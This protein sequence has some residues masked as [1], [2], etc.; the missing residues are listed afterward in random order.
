MSEYDISLKQSVICAVDEHETFLQCIMI[1]E[2]S[3]FIDHRLMKRGRE[4]ICFGALTRAM[5][6]RIRFVLENHCIHG[7]GS[8][9]VFVRTMSKHGH[10]AASRRCVGHPVRCVLPPRSCAA[11]QHGQYAVL[12]AMGDATRPPSQ[13]TMNS[14]GLA[15][16]LGRRRK[17]R[18]L[19]ERGF[20]ER[21][22]SVSVLQRPRLTGAAGAEVEPKT[23]RGKAD[24][25]SCRD[26]YWGCQG[27]L[28]R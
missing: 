22:L 19:K 16:P 24:C 27:P 13:E 15:D 4:Y 5:L 14:H 21:S 28:C 8:I 2:G 6:T 9:G 1:E 26:M 10:G 17:E 20:S 7:K 18:P 23:E 3:A 11:A 12:A 25:S